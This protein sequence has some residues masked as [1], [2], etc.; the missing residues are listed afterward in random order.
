MIFKIL[1]NYN[2]SDIQ[3]WLFRQIYLKCLAFVQTEQDIIWIYKLRTMQKCKLPRK[4]NGVDLKRLL[5]GLEK[6]II[7]S[8]K[9]Y[10]V[11]EGKMENA[12][13]HSTLRYLQ[14]LENVV[15]KRTNSVSRPIRNKNS[16][17]FPHSTFIFMF[18]SFRFMSESESLLL[19]WHD[20]RRDSHDIGN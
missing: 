20:S 7:V 9:S 14:V 8:I 18:R 11:L 6:L 2:Y 1:L 19:A 13:R 3:C 4:L 15:L 5:C 12:K 16:S 10:Y 17:V